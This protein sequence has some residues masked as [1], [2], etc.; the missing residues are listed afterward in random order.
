MKS[1]LFNIKM[2]L[3]DVD[4]VLTSGEIIYSSSGE[5]LK[6]FNSQDGLGIRLARMG[7]LITGIITGRESEMVRRRA[8]ELKIDIIS[9][10]N[11]DKLKPYEEIKNQHGLSDEEIAFIGDDIPDICIMKRVGFSAAVSNA[12]DEVKAISD[13][14][15]IAA[16]GYGAVR[17]VI[18][19]ILKRQGK[20]FDIIEEI[21]Q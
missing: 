4:G 1:K 10:G 19:K 18:E 16:G 15:T 5:E 11:F 20:F 9:Q 3:M 17:E 12:R 14:V 13:Y 21:S 6:N 8:G 7:G 2:I